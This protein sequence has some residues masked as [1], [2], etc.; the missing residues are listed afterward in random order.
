M[1]R[2][3]ARNMRGMKFTLYYSSAPAPNPMTREQRACGSTRWRSAGAASRS[4]SC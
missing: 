1:R 4:S 2:S 3:D